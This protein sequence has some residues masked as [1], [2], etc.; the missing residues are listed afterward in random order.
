MAP[1]SISC[2]C[3]RKFCQLKSD[4]CLG[5]K[6]DLLCAR[7]DKG[8]TELFGHITLC[9][10]LAALCPESSMQ[11]CLYAKNSLGFKQVYI[12]PQYRKKVASVDTHRHS[13]IHLHSKL[14]HTCT[15]SRPKT[16][17]PRSYKAPCK[18]RSSASKLY[19]NEGHGSRRAYQL[20]ADNGL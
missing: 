6:N 5:R 4:I 9:P 3:K 12:A 8:M 14:P 15:E 11:F 20:A 19:S 16:M 1:T 13:F 18:T 7:K 10:F 2:P 17:L